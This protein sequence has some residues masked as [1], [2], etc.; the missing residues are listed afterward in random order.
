MLEQGLW[1][2]VADCLGEKGKAEETC[3]LAAERNSVPHS[4]MLKLQDFRVVRHLNQ[5]EIY[6]FFI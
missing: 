1:I 2:S 4:V 3:K 6:N 5:T